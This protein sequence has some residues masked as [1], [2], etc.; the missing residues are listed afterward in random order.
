[1]GL[2]FTCGGQLDSWSH[3]SQEKQKSFSVTAE[4]GFNCLTDAS[5]D[6]LD[7]LRYRARSSA[8]VQKAIVANPMQKSQKLQY[9]KSCQ[10][11]LQTNAQ[12]H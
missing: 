2:Y 6:I 9:P 7:A 3:G 12:S 11:Y 8:A 1:M 4:V 10:T 5:S